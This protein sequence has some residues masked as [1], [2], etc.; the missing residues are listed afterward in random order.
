MGILLQALI[1]EDSENNA[2]LSA[3]TLE[4][5]GYEVVFERV[6]TADAM[7][8]ALAKRRWDIVLADYSIPHFSGAEA[9]MLVNARHPGGRAGAARG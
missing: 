7:A 5:G 3:R 4:R 6:Q 2:L 1:V 9:L 8:D